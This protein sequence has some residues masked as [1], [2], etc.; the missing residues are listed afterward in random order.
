MLIREAGYRVLGNITIF[1]TSMSL[2]FLKIKSNKTKCSNFKNA[3]YVLLVTLK[4]DYKM[5]SKL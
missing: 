5:F 1:A 2:K 3:V 4:Q